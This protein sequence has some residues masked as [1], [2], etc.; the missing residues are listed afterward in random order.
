MTEKKEK[1]VLR[2]DF[3]SAVALGGEALDGRGS[4]GLVY[5]PSGST[6][7][8]NQRFYNISADAQLYVEKLKRAEERHWQTR[9]ENLRIQSNAGYTEATQDKLIEIIN[10]IDSYEEREDVEV[11]KELKSRLYRLAA[12]VHL[13]NQ[14]NG[15][16]ELCA[17]FINQAQ[18]LSEGDDLTQCQ[19]TEALFLY[20][21]GDTQAALDILS[22]LS[23]DNAV[24]LRFAIYVET[25]Q[26][27]K[28]QDMINDGIVDLNRRE[29]SHDWAR[30]LLGL[31][32]V[33][34]QRKEVEDTLDLL[35]GENPTADDYWIGGQSLVR[36]AYA[37][38]YEFCL[39]HNVFPE[40]HIGLDLTEL[41]D[42]DVSAH[43]ANLLAQSSKLYQQHSC[44]KAAIRALTAAIR[45]AIDYGFEEDINS[46][47]AQLRKLDPENPLLVGFE[48]LNVSLPETERRPASILD[49]HPLLDDPIT[50]H[51]YILR[52]AISVSDTP[53]RA[54]EVALILEQETERFKLSDSSFANY[55]FVVLQLWVKSKNYERA[56]QWLDQSTSELSH[57]R[58]GPLLHI[59]MHLNQGNFEEAKIWLNRALDAVPEHPEVLAAAV[60]VHHQTGNHHKKLDYAKTLFCI[61]QTT[62]TARWYLGAL[63]DTSDLQTFLEIIEDIQDVPLS[64]TFVKRNRARALVTLDRGLEALDDLEWLYGNNIAEV[65]ELITLAQIYQLIAEPDKALAVLLN[66]VDRFPN[67]VE[68][69]LHLSN[70]YLMT[71]RREES[72]EWLLKAYQRFSNDPN[73][74][75]NLWFLSHATGYELHPEA[76]EA[77][78][79]F[80]P[81]GRFA[82]QSPF[83]R[84]SLEDILELMRSGQD[85]A[86]LR[87]TLY[88]TGQ[89][90]R[91]LLCAWRNVPMFLA[92]QRANFVGETRFIANGN[93]T[94]DVVR[95][96]HNCPRQAVLD[97]SALLTLWS[98]FGGDMLDFLSQ[99]FDKIWLPEALRAILLME[100]NKLASYGQLARYEAN[101]SVRDSLDDW[102]KKIVE[103]TEIDLE[104][105]WDITGLHTEVAISEQENLVHLNEHVP[106][107]HSP[108]NVPTIGLAVLTDI[109]CQS[110]EIDPMTAQ[111]TEQYARPTFEGEQA[112]VSRVVEERQVVVNISTLATWSMHH[113]LKPVFD[114]FDRL[115]IA[116]PAFVRLRAE[117]RSYEFDRQGFA[118]IRSFRRLLRQGEGN[119]L[120]AFD[121]I[122]EEDRVISHI[123]KQ[124]LAAAQTDEDFPSD[125]EAEQRPLSG[126]MDRYLDEL[127]G[128]ADRESIPIWTDDRWTK[129]LGIEDKR[130][131]YC[132]GTDSF[133]AFAYMY[134]DNNKSLSG[135]EYHTYYDQ[136]VTWRYYFLPINAD[137]IL[138]HLQNGRDPESK[139]L[140]HLLRHYRER[141]IEIWDTS[142]TQ[143]G[144]DEQFGVYL[145]GL[146]NQ[147]LNDLLRQLYEHDISVKDSSTIFSALDLSRHAA[148]RILG[149]EPSFFAS[150]FL[151][152]IMP[153]V[154]SNSSDATIQLSS[155][156]ASVYSEWLIELII[157]SG[158]NLAI[159]E[160][161]WYQLVQNGLAMLDSAQTELDQ[162]VAT[163]FMERLLDAMPRAI[164]RYLL[165]TDIGLHLEKDF[166]LQ[167][168]EHV[169]FGFSRADGS[170]IEIH[171]PAQEW[172]SDYDQ[173]L[174]QYLADHSKKAITVGLVTL[175]IQPVALGSILLVAEETPTEIHELHPDARGVIKYLDM[176][177]G[178]ISP[179]IIY[180]EALW[181]IGLQALEQH[182]EK[183]DFWHSRKVD[184]LSADQKGVQTGIEFLSHLLSVR[185][186]ALEYF[187][188]AA[189]LSSSN[190]VQLLDFI[191]PEIVQAWILMP[192]LDWSSKKDIRQ[193]IAQILL[194]NPND[195]DQTDPISILDRF[196]R[197]KFPDAPIARQSIAKILNDATLSSEK[198][199]VVEQLLSFA[200]SQSSLVLKAN[201][202][203]ALYEHYNQEQSPPSED[204]TTD[205]RILALMDRVLKGRASNDTRQVMA[206]L[207]EVAVCRWLYNLW[208][209]SMEP[210][211]DSIH[212]LAYLASVGASHIVDALSTDGQIANNV[213]QD[214][215]KLLWTEI[216]RRTMITG[217]EPQ[218]KGIYRP[219]CE[220][221]LNYAASFLL[222]GLLAYDLSEVN[223]RT[224]SLLK[225]A[226]L[227]C[228]INHRYEQ[229]FCSPVLSDPSWLDMELSTDVGTACAD[230]VEKLQLEPDAWPEE[231]QEL[232]ASIA[233]SDL[234][235]DARQKLINSIPKIEDEEL[236]LQ[237]VLRL[238]QGRTQMCSEWF[239]FLTNFLQ[240]EVLDRIRQS[241]MCYKEMIWQLGALLL[242]QSEEFPPDA[243][244]QSRD[245]MFEIP[246]D[247][248]ASILLRIKA[249]IL[250]QLVIW[251]FD[252]APV[253]QWVEEIV[254]NDR[255][256]VS[257]VRSVV[258]PFILLW[259]H[260]SEEI[261]DSLFS[262]FMGIAQLPGY[263]NLWE[264]ARLTRLQ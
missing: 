86:S 194:Q 179:D 37:R 58:L 180:R 211:D 66:C 227:V 122:P 157:A 24:R 128:I 225:T 155:D 250:S 217:I 139:P 105:G 29:T 236:L 108:P 89:I 67:T 259:P 178:F 39:S 50:D 102:S 203:L 61:L 176:L 57:T 53:S 172:Q 192:D 166:G 123:V 85:E 249:D 136:L 83:I 20:E 170:E 98:L 34:E 229:A 104:E 244:A 7:N 202:A 252:L 134:P 186:I 245:L 12:V 130:P 13:P 8:I 52:T 11:S 190:V 15:D 131:R 82:D 223:P 68:S 246:E 224:G 165:T 94:Q 239:D 135:L 30:V 262:T 253:C 193:S 41:I 49:L 112:L 220:N 54:A 219:A 243:L 183:T 69:Y 214:V 210:S 92:H 127:L 88:R 5:K 99:Y 255:F 149:R 226:M 3:D 132:F 1:H 16:A 55:V 19:I 234:A 199:N 181:E 205:E 23:A 87:E 182:Q 197:T 95:L 168:Q 150:L 204:C 114:Y 215:V 174:K 148:H 258:Q 62:Q 96:I 18:K 97:Y 109:L 47:V 251:G 256:D 184:L 171:L 56:V 74:L 212:R 121:T 191:K 240:P 35:I 241:E 27:E 124:Q 103:H 151:H 71:G 235:I 9:Y 4:Q 126:Y 72:F 228:G 118:D 73:V 40:L 222:K 230:L 32:T 177:P 231:E 6:V 115:H 100:Q 33:T 200:E 59:W 38:M 46:W 51:L 91:M 196:G 31:Y 248:S 93:Q 145:L 42:E 64:E 116:Q 117:I 26:I 90:P 77:F 140:E 25:N 185:S 44:E 198:G 189:Q 153:N 201:A 247:D 146:Y 162:H 21:T 173:A 163:I 232:L 167:I 79:S 260:Y 63:W 110:G 81:G 17:R 216:R 14:S 187:A 142:D 195:R 138:W 154:R 65:Y 261:R 106:P 43:A 175:K 263:D 242:H 10:E 36:L 158:T 101:C 60:I 120:I 218:P 113:G 125:S 213:A 254:Q 45:L 2:G 207:L 80:L 233:S 161:S 137:H 84:F 28:C 188:Q 160:E 264:F 206:I 78:Q 133:L 75:M 76:G 129:G 238:F 208:A 111:K 143:P 141:L 169:F 164:A 48:Q 257:L 237:C 22:N 119:G 209:N 144:V 156:E 147:Q 221:Y 152:T 159:I 107:S 70:I